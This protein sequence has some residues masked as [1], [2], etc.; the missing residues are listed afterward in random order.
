[1][2]I[3]INPIMFKKT[4]KPSVN[5]K[6]S[7]WNHFDPHKNLWSTKWIRTGWIKSCNTE[8]TKSGNFSWILTNWLPRHSTFI[9]SNFKH[10]S[11]LTH[12]PKKLSHWFSMSILRM[13]I[14]LYAVFSCQ[15][16][17][18]KYILQDLRIFPC[19]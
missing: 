3:K 19:W 12:L 7:L 6:S 11:W 2:K 13:N 17:T 16:S 18:K 5:S 1:M 4:T 10:Y 15:W 9:I 14:G 8:E